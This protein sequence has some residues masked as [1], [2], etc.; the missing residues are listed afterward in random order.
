MHEGRDDGDLRALALRE[1]MIFG[2]VDVYTSYSIDISFLS[3]RALRAR[4][5]ELRI[6]V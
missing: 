5:V 6:H 2:L 4:N 1:R 3:S